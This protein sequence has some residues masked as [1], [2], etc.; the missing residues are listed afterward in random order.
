M[1][2]K[3]LWGIGA[4]VILFSAYVVYLF[5]TTKN[6]SPAATS[7]IN[8][9]GVTLTVDYC[10]PYKKGRVVFGEL[11]EFGE[12]WRTGA[13][14]P[15]IIRFNKPVSIDGV[16]VDAGSYRLYTVP[17][18]KN[19]IVALNTELEKWGYYE[20]DYDLDVLRVTV[21]SEKMEVV[22]EQFLIELLESD[23]G[24]DLVLKWDDTKVKLPIKI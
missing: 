21:R 15:T 10:R 19:W 11:L 3:I 4:I 7:L 22:Q 12:Y 14:E 1:L 8:V 18:K 24:A 20:P 5:A 6:H 16:K 2:K 9:N 23:E 13:N 17:G